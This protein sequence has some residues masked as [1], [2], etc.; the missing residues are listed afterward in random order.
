MAKK[1]VDWFTMNGKHIPI[2]KGESKED[3][4]NR[5][6][7]DKNES[8]K[9]EQIAKNKAEADKLNEKS[10]SKSQKQIEQDV[11]KEFN[12]ALSFSKSTDKLERMKAKGDFIKFLSKNSR[13]D[14]SGKVSPGEH[15]M[16]ITGQTAWYTNKGGSL[17]I[18][19][20]DRYWHKLGN[21]LQLTREYKITDAEKQRLK[22]LNE[23]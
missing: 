2:Y 11:P 22:V 8:I 4:V 19:G 20:Q 7:A 21:D 6:I 10:Q 9:Q 23:S 5:A 14:E 3:A 18:L 16:N 1:V 13:A 12:K 17:F 15:I